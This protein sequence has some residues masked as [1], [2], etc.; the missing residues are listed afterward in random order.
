MPGG[1]GD[2]HP[3]EDPGRPGRELP[4]MTD[5]R[6]EG[7]HWR[8]RSSK[9]PFGAGERGRNPVGEEGLLRAESRAWT[10][11]EG[12][13][14]CWEYTLSSLRPPALRMK[15]NPEHGHTCAPFPAISAP[16]P[17]SAGTMETRARCLLRL[18]SVAHHR[19]SDQLWLLQG[20]RPWP[21]KLNQVP[22]RQSLRTPG[23]LFRV[24]CHSCTPHCLVW[25]PDQGPSLHKEGKHV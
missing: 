19:S 16:C 17:L 14:T 11:N 20:S 8:E 9:E 25:S 12:R 6:M 7:R 15:I 2:R 23:R 18:D 5:G 13:Q 22:L 21:P 1:R 10:R 3:Y 4:L 24:L